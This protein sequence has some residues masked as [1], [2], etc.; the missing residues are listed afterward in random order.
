LIGSKSLLPRAVLLDIAQG[1]VF[2][3]CPRT[4]ERCASIASARPGY[5]QIRPDFLSVAAQGREA[6]N[7][8]AYDVKSGRSL[9]RPVAQHVVSHASLNITKTEFSLVYLI[10]RVKRNQVLYFQAFKSACLHA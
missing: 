8:G 4:T 1:L 2:A 7:C 5:T 9:S 6:P 10:E 3:L